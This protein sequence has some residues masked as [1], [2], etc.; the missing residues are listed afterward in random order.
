M[1]VQRFD[2]L[3][4]GDDISGLIAANLLTH[5]HYKVIVLRNSIPADRYIYD[6][7]TLP[8]SPTI[9]SPLIYGEL[10]YQIRQ[11]FTLSQTE[12][13]A[14]AD[15]VDRFQFVTKRLRLDISTNIDE[16]ILEFFCELGIKKD[17]MAKFIKSLIDA[18]DKY[19]E[20]FNLHY[21]YPPYTFWDKRKI[22]ENIFSELNNNHSILGMLDSDKEREAFRSIL[23]FIQGV[24]TKDTYYSQESLLGFIF[25]DRWIILPSIERIKSTLLKR[26]E[27]KG[28]L[29]LHNTLNR[30]I[31]EK[32]GFNYYL[33]DEKQH[34]R[35][36]VDSCILSANREFIS[37][38]FSDKLFIKLNLKPL[39]YMIRY[40]T[41]FVITT[42]SIPEFASNVI[43]YK[44]D[45]G[46]QG[47]PEVYQI[48][49]TKAMRGRA[50]IKENRIFSVTTY[51]K[52]E[53]FHKKNMDIFNQRAKAVLLRIFPFIEDNILSMSSILNAE[54]LLDVSL[55]E[56]KKQEYIQAQYIYF[57][58]ELKDGIML[59]DMKTGLDN[60]IN[61]AS[62]FSPIG[63]YGDFMS[64]VRASEIVSKN[65][66][67]K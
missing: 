33:R 23:M 27:E 38:I 54:S 1:S 57:A 55:N 19:I 44:E 51:I 10:M 4:V 6:G 65:I 16:T 58:D 13:E 47:V 56:I 9:I 7:Y 31:L 28:V 52:P 40:T 50:I 21:P 37:S 26:L 29:I 12:F 35:F 49:Y 67:G 15:I 43:F 53:E 22:K 34:N 2:T 48:S 64:A 36:R 17:K 5:F 45:V 63:I 66:L 25:S 59:F 42:K 39:P 46:N 30:Y 3:I 24:L 61:T 20:A 8:I 14:D 60:F 32:R 41:N 18:R 11:F 62:V